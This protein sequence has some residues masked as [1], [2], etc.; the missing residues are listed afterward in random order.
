MEKPAP[1]SPVS[2]I[3]PDRRAPGG[4]KAPSMAARR[5]TPGSARNAAPDAA[6]DS[7]IVDQMLAYSDWWNV[8]A[9]KGSGSSRPSA[10]PDRT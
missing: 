10:K 8:R 6:P 2:Q 4:R 7:G 3:N 1:L 9:P 5:G